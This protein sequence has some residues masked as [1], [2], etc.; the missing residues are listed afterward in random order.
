MVPVV[1][2]IRA[3]GAMPVKVQDVVIPRP[4]AQMLAQLVEGRRAQQVHVGRQLVLFNQLDQQASDRA[5]PHVS[6]KGPGNHQQN[7]HPIARKRFRYVSGIADSI[8]LALDA[9]GMSQEGPDL[10][11]KQS[12]PRPRQHL[13]VVAGDLQLKLCVIVLNRRIEHPS[14]RTASQQAL[15]RFFAP[16]PQR[17]LHPLGVVRLRWKRI[18]KEIF[19]VPPQLPHQMAVRTPLDGESERGRQLDRLGG[20][21][22]AEPSQLESR[23]LTFRQMPNDQSSVSRQHA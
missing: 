23:R 5:V 6:L 10:V 22:V 9:A 14:A 19:E 8:Q 1:A 4:L 12:L 15:E 16:P 7:V 11:I 17:P 18:V 3:V 20:L 13:G 21:A 2:R